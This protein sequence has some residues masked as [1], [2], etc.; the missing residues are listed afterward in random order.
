MSGKPPGEPRERKRRERV[1]A[2]ELREAAGLV[3]QTVLDRYVVESVLGAGAMGVV[4]R[5][6]HV[7]LP[8]QVAIKVMHDDVER[9]PSMLAR[10]RREAVVAGKLHHP[11][12]A[13]VIDVGDHAGRPVMVLEF[14]DGPSLADVMTR[15]HPMPGARIVELVRGILAGLDHAH[16]LGLV[17]RDLKPDNVIVEAE[18]PRIVDFG[19][20]F[21]RDPDASDDGGRLT[22]SGMIVGTPRYMAPE[23]AAGGDI[24]HR[25]DLFSLGVIVYEM[26]AGAPP[27]EGTPVEVAVSNMTFDAPAIAGADQVLDRF[28]RRLFRRDLA[29]RFATARAALDAL[30][31]DV[32]RALATIS[33]P[34]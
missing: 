27:F 6:R 20:A 8:R 1:A 5:G 34:P 25:V 17:H 3:G 33:L 11:N 28:M 7:N 4:Y 31:L 2:A 18:G 32:D 12:V 19:I 29:R 15:E 10:F 16:G 26:L 14:A 22:A 23:Q 21:L 24:D 30:E 13:A 9:E